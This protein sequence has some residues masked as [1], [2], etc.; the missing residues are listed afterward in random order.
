MING[1]WEFI[2]REAVERTADYLQ[3][4]L[5]EVFEFVPV[6]FWSR[7]LKTGCIFLRGAQ[8]EEGTGQD[9]DVPGSDGDATNVV[10]TFLREQHISGFRFADPGRGIDE[11]VN[12]ARSENCI[13]IGSPKSNAATEILLSRYFDAEPFDPSEVN[14]RKIPFGFCWPDSTKIVKQS[15]LTCSAFARKKVKERAGIVVRAGGGIHVPADYRAPEEFRAWATSKGEEGKDCGLIF[16]ANKPFGTDLDVKLIVLAGFSGIG[17]LGAARALVKDFR[18]LEPQP[19]E[20]YVYGVVQC[21]YT[22]P[23]NSDKRTFKSFDWRVRING[24]WPITTKTE[25]KR[26]PKKRS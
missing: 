9:V 3:L 16:V 10:T 17:T 15:S 24:G 8:D 12:R 26:R 7:I 14:R 20:K 22:K 13:V 2:A 21:W 6:D 19:K 11:L 23:A 5:T 4:E 25:K 1:D 18:Y